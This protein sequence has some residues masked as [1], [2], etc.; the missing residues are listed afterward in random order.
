M[1]TFKITKKT[2]IFSIVTW[3][4]IFQSALQLKID[5]MRYIDEVMAIVGLFCI[6]VYYGTT[7]RL[8]KKKNILIPVVA[9]GGFIVTGLVGN[10]IFDYQPLGLVLTDLFTNI[11]FYLA[12]VAGY[13]FV[14]KYGI[15]IAEKGMLFATEVSITIVF[16]VFMAD[17]LLN[18]YG[19]EYRYGLRSAVLFFKHETYLAAAMVFAISVVLLFHRRHYKLFTS[20][21][22]IILFFT[23]RGKAIGATCTLIYLYAMHIQFNR[24]PK[25]W[26]I[27]LVGIFAILLGW[28]Q[29]KFYYIE[30]AGASA[31]SVLTLTSLKVAKDYFPI[32]TGFATFASDSA[33]KLYSPVYVK[34]G[35]HN[36]YELN[37]NNPGAFFN[38]TFWPI[39]IGQTGVIGTICYT[40][41]VLKMFRHC[42]RKKEEDKFQY[43]VS[44]FIMIYLLISTTSEPA[45]NNSISVPLAFLL[46]A[47]FSMGRAE[48]DSHKEVKRI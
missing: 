44:M 2:I 19:G 42:V 5:I 29:I 8:I 27:A 37:P 33:A 35:L 17:R 31:R 25:R 6:F 23:L 30:L 1:K 21:G 38:D 15:R 32:G 46:G 24:K 18:I 41:V 26:Q 47:I 14:K 10:A 40:F 11:K 7:R 48:V 39:I 28:S 34:Y 45:F 4:M 43:V 36:F 3:L 13:Y 12:L 22:L 20:L 9:L 16:V